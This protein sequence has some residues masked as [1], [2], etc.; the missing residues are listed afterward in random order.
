MAY[1]L[2]PRPIP[3]LDRTEERRT[4]ELSQLFR[5]TQFN[6]CLRFFK[7][8]LDVK[9]QLDDSWSILF[10]GTRCQPGRKRAKQSQAEAQVDVS[11]NLHQVPGSHVDD[12]HRLSPKLRVQRAP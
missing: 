7:L 6:S 8:N 2:G 9:A 1:G 3:A 10:S 5:L 4:L 11:K 12:H